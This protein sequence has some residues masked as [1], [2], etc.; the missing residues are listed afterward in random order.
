G[1]KKMNILGMT[2][3]GDG[4]EPLVKNLESIKKVQFEE[5]CTKKCI[6]KFLGKTGFY[7]GFLP[8]YAALAKP[9]EEC[10]SSKEADKQ[11]REEDFEQLKKAFEDRLIL[12]VLNVERPFEI[13]CDASGVQAGA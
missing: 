13:W 5:L 8:N 3:S 4:L 2:L 11:V 7:R 12:G 6:K 10:T 1:T 9:L